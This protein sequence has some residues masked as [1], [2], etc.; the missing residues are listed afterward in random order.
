MRYSLQVSFTPTLCSGSSP[1]STIDL[2]FGLCEIFKHAHLKFMVYGRKQAS[3]Q[4]SIHTHVRNVVTLMW[5]SLRLAPINPLSYCALC[6]NDSL[7]VVCVQILCQ[8][9]GWE[10]GE[11]GEVTRMVTCR[12]WLLGL[13]VNV[14]WL[15]V[16]TGCPFSPWLHGQ[17]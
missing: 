15:G 7:C 4:T 8:Q 3:K 6:R 16:G 11:V 12:W 14:P 13:A 9:K 17:A 10:K 2:R 5:G 1:S